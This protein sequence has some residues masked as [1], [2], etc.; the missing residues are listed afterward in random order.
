MSFYIRVLV[1]CLCMLA[2][3]VSY[4]KWDVERDVTTDGREELIYYAKTN[5]QGQK[6]VVDK[7]QKRLIFIQKDRLYK[8]TITQITIDGVPFEVM[9]DPF[10]HYPEQTAIVFEDKDEVLKKIFLAKKIE[11][12]V[13]YGR[14]PGISV[15]QIK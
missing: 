14:E 4:A 15:F 8:R 11:V 9:S 13:L 7:Y 12:K 2:S 5:E 10:S 3:H 1:I 6:L